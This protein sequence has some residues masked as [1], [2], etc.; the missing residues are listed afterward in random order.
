MLA[1]AAL[2][3]G[4][5]S[6]L[7]APEASAFRTLATADKAAFDE[8]IAREAEV[9]LERS[10]RL[11]ATN[12]GRVTL[13]NCGRN[14]T[15]PC[16]VTYAVA[17]QDYRLVRSA[18][19]MRAL[20]GGIVRYSEAMAELCEADDLDAVKA[21]SEGAAGAVKALATLAGLPVIAGAI[22]DAA[23]FAGNQRLRTRRREALL[24]V[25]L[26]AQPPIRA[27][28]RIITEQ[29]AALEASVLAGT[30]ENIAAT[31]AVLLETQAEERRIVAGASRDAAR[32]TPAGR[33]RIDALR[34]ARIA[35]L[36]QLVRQSEQIALARNLGADW[37][38]LDAAHDTLIA[39]LRDPAVS[40]EDALA[41]IDAFLALL[42]AIKS[43]TMER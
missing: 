35:A 18:P 27:A 36:A 8:V 37:N 14:D 16:T 26:A 40:L 1:L 29:A 33:A 22:I 21:K 15:D 28:S 30:S 20:L 41:D 2:L 34:G 5:A 12:D 9:G 39:R 10:Q 17:G 3:P 38:K 19:N 42:D 24:R 4:C 11:L 32:L 7:P 43:G 13:R 25:A 23:A 6:T 31:Q